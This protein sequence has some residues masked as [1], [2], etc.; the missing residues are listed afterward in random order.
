MMPLARRAEIERRHDA[1]E[2]LIHQESSPELEQVRMRLK[3]LGAVPSLC[4]TLNMGVGSAY[5]WE[6]LL[7]VSPAP[8]CKAS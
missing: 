1:V 7:K 3:E 5:V 4:S 2:L 8:S 6:K